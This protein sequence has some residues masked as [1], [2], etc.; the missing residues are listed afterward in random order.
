MNCS[1][2][3]EISSSRMSRLLQLHGV[4]F[5]IYG[6]KT[7]PRP[8]CQAGCFKGGQWRKNRKCGFKRN[9]MNMNGLHIWTTCPSSKTYS[10][11]LNS[12]ESLGDAMNMSRH[13]QAGFFA[14][15]N[16]TGTALKASYNMYNSY[17]SSEKGS[18]SLGR[19]LQRS[20]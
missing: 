6:N 11:E 5:G 4:T 7:I 20:R 18:K 1:F 19:S 14:A 13:P 9:Q 2:C 3:H 16:C 8:G 12:V 15:R 17:G 10:K